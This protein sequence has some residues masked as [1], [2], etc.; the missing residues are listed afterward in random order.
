MFTVKQCLSN[1][2]DDQADVKFY[3]FPRRRVGPLTSLHRAAGGRGAFSYMSRWPVVGATF[4]AMR[5]VTRGVKGIDLH[6]TVFICVGVNLIRAPKPVDTPQAPWTCTIM[7]T[8]VAG[9]ITMIYPRVFD[10]DKPPPTR[11]ITWYLGITFG[12]RI[13]STTDPQ[14]VK[15]SLFFLK[16]N[17]A[18]GWLAKG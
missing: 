6:V 15:S 4:G 16:K 9:I 1:C 3:P 18:R 2:V 13:V 7:S 11:A 10:I 5:E 8:P 14:Q 12:H 17:V